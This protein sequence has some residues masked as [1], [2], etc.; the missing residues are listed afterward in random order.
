MKCLDDCRGYYAVGVVL[1]S[2]R[3]SLGGG[4]VDVHQSS[5]GR[6]HDPL[7][8]RDGVFADFVFISRLQQLVYLCIHSPAQVRSYES[9]HTPEYGGFL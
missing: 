1:Y 4:V 8:S 9:A 7:L 3:F 2:K 6:S 5:L